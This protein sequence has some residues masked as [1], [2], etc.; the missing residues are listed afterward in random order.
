MIPGYKIWDAYDDI[1]E[2]F[3]TIEKW[4]QQLPPPKPPDPG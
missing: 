2:F 1:K 4:N 3:E